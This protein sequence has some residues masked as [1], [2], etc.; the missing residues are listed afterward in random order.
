MPVET[1]LHVSKPSLQLSLHN[2][3][4]LVAPARL[5]PA[6]WAD[7]AQANEAT[8]AKRWALTHPAP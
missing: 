3:L 1:K 2:T 8:R 5:H 4:S 7:C 6:A